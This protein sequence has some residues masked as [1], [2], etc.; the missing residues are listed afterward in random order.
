MSTPEFARALA[1]DAHG[2][3]KYGDEPYVKHL[4]EVATLCEPYGEKAVIVAYL[5]DALEDT[6]LQA[7]TVDGLFGS[8]VC[9]LVETLTDPPTGSRK[10]RKAASYAKLGAIGAGSS[11][12][13]ALVVKAADRLAN[14]RCCASGGNFGLLEMYRKE[15]AAFDAAVRRAGLNDALMDEVALV[16]ETT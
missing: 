5:H 7:Q 6:P 4:D 16:L 3:Q 11:L 8:E 9:S 1:V 12:A 2:D 10:E 14:V 15:Q 13:L